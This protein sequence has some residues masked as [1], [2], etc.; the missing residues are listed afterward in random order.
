[1]GQVDLSRV[2]GVS[3]AGTL[4]VT[5]VVDLEILLVADT[6]VILAASRAGGSL[7]AHRVTG[8]TPALFDTSSL[9]GGARVGA[10][11]SLLPLDLGA[12]A[13]I[14]LTGVNRAG[15]WSY[16]LAGNG[17]VSTLGTRPASVALPEA[18]SFALQV[19]TGSGSQVY[20]L[21]A[22]ADQILR[23][24]AGAGGL[25]GAQAVQAA[26]F[27]AGASPL[28]LAHSE[29]SG[30]SFLL[31]LGDGGGDGLL[32]SYRMG[33]GGALDLVARHTTA[34]GVGIAAPVALQVAASGPRDYAIVAGHGSNSLTTFE[35]T[36]GGLLIPRDHLLD[37]GETR[38]G[39]PRLLETAVQG[40][41][42]YVA[43][44][45]GED[46]VSLFRLLPG[47]RLLHLGSCADRDD[48]TLAGIAAL[49]LAALPDGRL[50]IAVAS[51]T[52]PG[53]TW[54]AIDP[55]PQGVLRLGGGA[56]ATLAGSGGNDVLAG[57]AGGETLAGGQGDDVIMDGAGS[58][59]MTG[60]AG[61]DVFVLAG[62]GVSDV[63]TDFDPGQDRLDL[64][65]WA[66]LRNAGQLTIQQTA[67]GV[68]I[69][70]ASEYL[71]IET[72]DGRP[73]A[74]E[75][76]RGASLLD[77]DRLLPGWTIETFERIDRAT[78]GAEADSM[79]GTMARD[80]M[81][82]GAGNDTLLSM[83]GDDE[84]DGGAGADLMNGGPGSDLYKVDD[85]GDRVVESRRWDGHDAV[86]SS[87]DFWLARAHVED[88]TLIGA[89]DI[90]G[91]GNGLENVIIGNSGDNILDGG[92]NND[93]LVGGL[94]DDIYHIRAPQDM[95]VEAAG[96]GI[97]T[98]KAFRA[99]ALDANVERLYLQTQR[100]AAG[101]GVAGI[102]GIGNDLAN[103]IIGNPYENVI[104]GREGRDV[105]KGQGGADTFVFDRA[106]GANN[107]DR[108]LD[109]VPGEDALWIKAGLFGM[110]AGEVT[111]EMLH[112][113]AVA[114]E[115]DDRVLYDQKTGAVRI[116]PDGSGP[117]K[118]WVTFV[119]ETR[120]WVD[121]H[122]ILL[123]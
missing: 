44:A 101:E 49:D 24:T 76:L 73:L 78:G 23:W 32:A 53:V 117:A 5:G 70:F 74:P 120:P 15:L 41:F 121:E 69:A 66:F 16:D 108:V 37:S 79:T 48:L 17:G 63:I 39:A 1:M 52:E 14:A 88:L 2:A 75:V 61:A 46:G 64:S 43:A 21:Q 85:L 25:L 38:F 60:G 68:S 54:I 91:V 3:A 84:L 12:G 26:G 10:M 105:L 34:D 55:G 90:R 9:P 42:T 80:L 99:Y 114:G 65:E 98:V 45:G 33:G 27:G 115:A 67:W 123:I 6:P 93:R 56:A 13:E 100:N 18:L 102:N 113:G 71:R 11:I 72:A 82:G 86:E 95:A 35:I 31:A 4:S 118:A 36:P 103:V 107:V 83:A 110:R 29:G 62:D 92:K 104:I 111:A 116:D 109:F 19:G 81:S 119:L 28:A 59:R 7:T 22:G 112:F 58:D 30:G 20:G 106:P 50:G 57:G 122:D 47:G 87:V 77:G 8:D 51:G 40:S 94:G 96:G 97:D 89:T